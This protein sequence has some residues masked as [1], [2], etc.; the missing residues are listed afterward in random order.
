[1]E[2]VSYLNLVI[3]ILIAL[4]VASRGFTV[5]EIY[6]ARWASRFGIEL[7]RETAPAVRS[8]LRTTRR[9]RT[10][11]GLIGFLAPTI[12]FG[13]ATPQGEADDVGGWAVTLMLVGYLIGALIAEIAAGSLASRSTGT[14]SSVR[15]GDHLPGYAV[16]LQRGLA[17]AAL[18]LVG[19][20]PLT[21]PG[22]GMAGLPDAMFVTVLGFGVAIG[23]LVVESFQRRVIGSARSNNGA[24]A[25]TDDA[26]RAS[27]LHI[28]A[29]GAIA[30]LA[31][32][33]GPLLGLAIVSVSETMTSGT[34]PAEW[35]AF[36]VMGLFLLS[37][38][39]FWLHFGKPGG[40]GIR[41]SDGNQ[42]LAST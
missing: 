19:L 23:A 2:Q 41:S 3:P 21:D 17:I 18:L 7:N 39:Y 28:L 13:I 38:L 14:R 1:M 24:Q 33:V 29:G 32:V 10:A 4:A 6:M 16:V 5:D 12:Y 34:G 15:L 9:L 31:N 20:Y 37:S 27:S 35:I 11:G 30:L 40:F 36:S 22:L 25:A 8:Y 42:G 26:M